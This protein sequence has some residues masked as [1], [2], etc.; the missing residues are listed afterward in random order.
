MS[1][2]THPPA[3][4][5]GDCEARPATRC[6]TVQ[7]LLGWAVILPCCDICASAC[8]SALITQAEQGAIHAELAT[9]W[10]VGPWAEIGQLV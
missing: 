5:C 8:L 3:P 10:Y 1:Y 4:I 9:Y 7:D 6:Y 2:G